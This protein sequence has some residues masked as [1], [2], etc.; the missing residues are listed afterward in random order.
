MTQQISYFDKIFSPTIKESIEIF[1][2]VCVFLASGYNWVTVM[3]EI[4]I[5]SAQT[6]ASFYTLE[7]SSTIPL[8]PHE[9]GLFHMRRFQ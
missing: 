6:M 4:P 3:H 1:S 5:S 8:V 7:L 2:F 9:R